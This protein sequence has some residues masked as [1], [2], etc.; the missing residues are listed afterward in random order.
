M[1]RRIGLALGPA[2]AF[3]LAWGIGMAHGQD[4]PDFDA[5]WDYDRPAETEQT[6]RELLPKAEQSGDASYALQLMTQIARTLGLQ[7]KFEEA[8]AVLN[9]VEAGL[10]DDLPVARIRY[11]LERGRAFN[12]SGE[13]EEARPLFLEAFA[14]AHEAREDFHAVDAAHMIAIIEPTDQQIAWNRKAMSIAEASKDERA[15]GWLGSLYNNLGWTYHDLGRF[16]EA[17]ETFT[18]GYEFRKAKG[19]VAPMRIARWTMG[20]ALRSLHR[21]DEALSIQRELEG[22]FAKSGE[23]DGFVFEEIAECLAAS[24]DTA[25]AAPYFKRAY[26][27][28]SKIDWVMESEP[29]RVERLKELGGP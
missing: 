22:A 29:E 10:T 7:R 12:S 19:Q 4:L 13:Q 23:E 5:L 18:K 8:H 25:S 26:G 9:G 15:R 2:W 11:L 14:A 28:L 6:F 21:I 1:T 24:G 3:G 17:L 16:E 27:L 20:R